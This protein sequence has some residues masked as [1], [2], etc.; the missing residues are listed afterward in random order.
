MINLLESTKSK[1][2]K[3]ENSEYVSHL[4]ITEVALVHYNIVNNDYQYDSWV[5]CTFVP[6]NHLVNWWI[7]CLKTFYFGKPLTQNFHIFKYE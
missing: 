6:S 7:F 2:T 1:I 5:L 4:G 3:N